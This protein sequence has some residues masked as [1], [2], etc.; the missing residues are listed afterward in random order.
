MPVF[1]LS[2]AVTVSAYTVVEA[3]T[4]EEAIDLSQERNPVIGGPQSGADENES[5]I[6]EDADGEATDIAG[7]EG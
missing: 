7:E 1:N 3:E 6:I 4:L 2:A 5:W